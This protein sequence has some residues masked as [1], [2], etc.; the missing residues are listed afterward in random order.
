MYVY[1]RYLFDTHKLL[2]KIKIMHV[3][4]LVISHVLI[5]KTVNRIN[6]PKV[7]FYLT[8]S[9]VFSLKKYFFLVILV[10]SI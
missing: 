9:F 2:K 3:R 10:Q 4:Q 6:I 8:I 5:K 7:P 1:L